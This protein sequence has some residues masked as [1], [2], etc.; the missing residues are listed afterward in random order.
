[1]S[2]EDGRQAS[3]AQRPA[4][5]DKEAWKAYWQAQNQ[6]WRTELEIDRERQQ[7]LAERR[8]IMP[9]IQQGIYPFK[10]IKLNR[11]DVEWLLAT[12]KGGQEPLDWQNEKQQSPTVLD[13]RGADLCEVDL[14]FLPLTHLQGGL[15]FD[16]W[17]HTTEEQRAAAALLMKKAD[18]SGAQLEG[19]DLSGAQLEGADLRDAQLEGANLS[20]AQ[21]EGA[22]LSGA[23]LERANLSRAQLER[24]I[25][26]GAQLK[27]ARL[28]GAQLEGANL[29]FAQLEEADLSGA[30][31]ERTILWEAQLEGANLI[32][33][34]IEGA[35]LRDVILGNKMHIGPQIADVQWSNTNLAVVDWSEVTI[36]GDEDVAR[37]EKTSDGDIKD[38]KMRL[39]EYRTAVRASRQLAVVLQ[40]QGL[41]EEA[42]HFAYR[43][44]LMQRVVARRLMYLPQRSLWQRIRAFGSYI[45][46]LFLDII[47][48]YGYHPAKTLF[49]YLLVIAGFATA[50]AVFGHL[51]PFPDALVFSFMSF[52]GRGFFPSLAGASLHN[53]L[54]VLAAAE[55][56]IGLFIE[57]SFFATFTQRFFGK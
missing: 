49:W 48:G 43:A 26:W 56:V 21:L 9:D 23:Q 10:G 52:H 12:H 32:Q 4:N 7:Y 28:I 15:K 33:A 31:L 50:Y 3:I 39:D 2:E 25:L 20:G 11:T 57:I 34:H 54:V 5:E 24:A 51:P 30:Q 6:P 42:A 55:A 35:D 53:P 29:S 46:S 13:L 40:A 36:L 38:R 8:V 27:G 19:A 1:V 44:Q 18:L 16:E 47:A 14:S 37:Q 17:I 45:F 22:N 41:N